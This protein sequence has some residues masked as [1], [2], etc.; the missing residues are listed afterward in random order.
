MRNRPALLTVLTF[1][2]LITV[3]TVALDLFGF[4]PG[5][6]HGFLHAAFTSTS[7]VCVTGLTVVDLQKEM[8]FTGQL[9]V[10]ILLQV[11]GLGVL[12]LSNW[13]ML[14]LRRRLDLGGAVLT[15]E[16]YG[17][18]PR[19]TPTEL[20]GHIVVFTF[21]TEALGAALLLV[22]F[23]GKAPFGTALWQAVFHAVSAF[24]N[25]GF[26]LFSTSLSAYR[27]DTVVNVV[28]MALIFA[29]GIGF[30]AAADVVHWFG[31]RVR[32]QRHRLHFHTRVVLVT[33]I[34]L[35]VAGAVLFYVFESTSQLEPGGQGAS[36]VDSLFLS[37]TA[38][39]AGF[40]TVDTGHL[41][42]MSLLVLVLLMAVGASPG[43]T[44]GGIKT[45]TIAIISA[46]VWSH[47]LNRPDTEM[48]GRSVP[49]AVAAKAMAIFMIYGI[50]VILALLSLQATEFG[51]VP[52]DLARGLFLEHL[53]E[54]VSALSTVGLSTG[55]TTTL[56]DRGLEIIM[57]CMFIG[58]VGP[59][60]LAASVIGERRRLAY[61]HP[62]GDV[63][64]G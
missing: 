20:L 17:G 35:I 14:T 57:A 25:A 7:A 36:V 60:V 22:R 39:T 10:L 45:S 6:G 4:A 42:N 9:L 44:G 18:L 15:R 62:E 61:A 58:R 41:T 5:S 63:M 59:L 43:S 21:V 16:T 30:V 47:V 52:H 54:V 32:R 56:S 38:R 23:M 31:R 37:V 28:I 11:G 12:T 33:S 40:N 49:R 13:V 34:V 48:L 50:V 55:V 8:P 19:V 53:F 27:G 51:D 2:G 46:R 1:L 3:G 29:G 64:V 24:C 26:S